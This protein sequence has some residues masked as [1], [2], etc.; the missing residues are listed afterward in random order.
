M[1]MQGNAAN[2]LCNLIAIDY[3]SPKRVLYTH[4]MLIILCK[5][6]PHEG[7]IET[8][9]ESEREPQELTDKWVCA[10]VPDC[11]INFMA[12]TENKIEAALRNAEKKCETATA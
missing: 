4:Q 7:I 6:C 12:S 10:E 8:E 11:I 2:P 1:I 9:R 5:T 3:C